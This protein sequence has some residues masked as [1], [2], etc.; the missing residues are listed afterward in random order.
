MLAAGFEFHTPADLSEALRLLADKG[1]EA[2]VLAGGM[3]MVPAVNLGLLRPTCVVSLNHVSGL[4]SIDDSG[5]ELRIGALVRHARIVSDPA[6]RQHAPALAAAASVIGDVQVRN[7]GTIGGSVAHADPAADYL[8]VLVAFGATIVVQGPQGT[9]ELPAREFFL[10]VMLTQL[11][12]D[13]IVTEVRVP[14]L[15]PGA[16]SGYARLAR[17]E[18]AFAIANAAAFVDGSRCVIGIGAAVPAPVVTEL[19][20]GS[21]PDDAG[22]ERVA[23]AARAACEDAYDDLSGSAGYRRAMAGVYARR[24]VSLA[25]EA[26]G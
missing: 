20:L 4:D 5:D 12:A 15:P 11:T 25:I 2:K 9:R 19:A 6:I 17:V 18:G 26:R 10:G 14:K 22:L 21:Q 13:E 7:R 23:E 8:P 24:A 1:P 3:S 16:G